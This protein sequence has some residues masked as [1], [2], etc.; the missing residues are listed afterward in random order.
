[1]YQ[2]TLDHFGNLA[3]KK[4]SMLSDSPL[5]FAVGSLMAGAY[6]GIG[7]ILIFSVGGTMDPAWQKLIMGV[8]FGIALTL[9]VFA[10][11]EL[12]TGHTMYM[13]FG[14][15][16]RQTTLGDLGRVWV[17][18]WVFNLI[19]SVGLAALF[20]AGGGG[21]LLNEGSTLLYD[22]AAFKMNSSIAALVARATLCNWLVCLALVDGGAHRERRH[23]G[24]RHF[25]VP[26]CL[27]RQRLRAQ[28]RQHDAAG[29][30]AAGRPSRYDQ[31]RRHGL[32]PALGDGRQHHRR[33]R[34]D[35]ARLLVRDQRPAAGP[36]H[37]NRAE[38]SPC[39]AERF[40][41]HA[42]MNASP[43]AKTAILFFVIL[44]VI[45]TTFAI[46]VWRHEDD[47]RV[48][49]RLTDQT[50]QTVTRDHLG[51]RHL[52]VFFGFTSCVDICPIQMAK[53]TRVMA[54]LDQTGH[55]SRITP[56]FISVDPER[57]SPER[58]A[59]WLEHFD[60]RF[61]GLTGSR[62]ALE[63]AADSFRT[64]LEDLPAERPE[65]YQI[66]HSTM[67]FVVDPFG[68]IVDFLPGTADPI[69]MAEKIR[70]IV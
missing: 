56:V 67:T 69:A 2:D 1:M 9:V 15:L 5:A 62:A 26:V 34:S 39:Q 11:S 63:G 23:Q 25:L 49:F 66:T 61:V 18:S 35:G 51:G 38:R 17:A 68:R 40:G 41:R 29:D 58:V 21:V 44:G 8:S 65:G 4:A 13:V 46:T 50:G 28:R 37:R 64:L 33:Q 53:L 27:H 20:A 3:Q 16:M 14:C 48:Q 45:A 57:D 54:E 24:D 55:G 59:A 22:I 36:G 47:S 42:D 70:E 30:L 52:M 6:V 60:D 43:T 32:Q 12:F 31:R 7:I 10:G 19:G